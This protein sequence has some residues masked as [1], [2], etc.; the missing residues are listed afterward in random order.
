MPGGGGGGPADLTF[1]IEEI[2]AINAANAG[3]G[4]NSQTN[5][6]GAGGQGTGSEA[7][8][9]TDA[10]S[11]VLALARDE[12]RLEN[13]YR[14]RIARFDDDNG[15]GRGPFRPTSVPLIITT[16]AQLLRGDEGRFIIFW[17]GPRSVQ[18][19]FPMRAAQQQTRSGTIYHTWRNGSRS[20]FFDEPSAQFTFQAGNIMPVRVV[21]QQGDPFFSAS[22]GG[23][24][25]ALPSGLFDFYEFFEILNE[26]KILP[27]GRPNFVLIA[28]HSLVYPEMML[29]GFFNPE[30]I[31]F[32]E[33]AQ[34]PTELTWNATFKVRSTEP[35]FYNSSALLREWNGAFRRGA[36]ELR[37]EA[38]ANRR[39]QAFPLTPGTGG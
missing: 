37:G 14:R 19:S 38:E 12:E 6:S 28:Y 7:S 30:G 5:P 4:P 9:S 17:A 36:L 27:D 1:T 33:D 39:Q 8:E 15:Q 16:E 21:R 3:R 22:R 34:Q 10:F 25:A 29:R 2:D 35:P 18:W 20:T 24:V 23:R 13:L 26:E 11:D 31:T 32:S